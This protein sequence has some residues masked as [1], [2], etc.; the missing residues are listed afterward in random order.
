MLAH[1]LNAPSAPLLSVFKFTANSIPYRPLTFTNKSTTLKPKC[2]LQSRKRTRPLADIDNLESDSK[3]KRRLRL[4]LITSR[5]SR[6]FSTP[7]TH[8]VDRGS[9][10]IAVW[11][12]KKSL[13]PQVL[14]KAA[15]MNHIRCR[16]R[17]KEAWL[18]KD[19]GISVGEDERAE[20]RRNVALGEMELTR[21]ESPNAIN[22]SWPLKA[23][24]LVEK[25]VTIWF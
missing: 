1:P 9:S 12:K 10:K 8:I 6:P 19:S 22:V 24:R 21:F 13:V 18:R 3:K 17:E 25:F 23:D 20:M 16:V 5:L 14:R 11:A 15:I 7:A 2:P 4:L